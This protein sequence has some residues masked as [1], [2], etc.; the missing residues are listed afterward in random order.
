EIDAAA[1][2]RFAELLV[3]VRTSQG[4]VQTAA[5]VQ[6]AVA[7][8]LGFEPACV[9]VP[10][11]AIVGVSFEIEF[12]LPLTIGGKPIDVRGD[13]QLVQP[14]HTPIVLDEFDGQP[15]EQVGQNWLRGAHTKIEHVFHQR[16]A[17][18]P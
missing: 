18:V 7:D 16:C 12:R 3:N 1:A 6:Q 9:H 13:H 4:A 10:K 5:Y 8:K 2:G 14:L 15:V 17:K 11:R